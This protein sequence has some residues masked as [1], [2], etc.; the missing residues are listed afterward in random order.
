MWLIFTINYK[1]TELKKK[2]K[3]QPRKCLVHTYSLPKKFLSTLRYGEIV[4]NR[5]YGSNSQETFLRRQMKQT[6]TLVSKCIF[7]RIG[8]VRNQE[9]L[10]TSPAGETFG[11]RATLLVFGRGGT[12]SSAEKQ[13]D[14]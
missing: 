9:A 1:T 6:H 14:S 12:S 5:A 2:K 8:V 3:I 10:S 4:H 7:N 13:V 11:V